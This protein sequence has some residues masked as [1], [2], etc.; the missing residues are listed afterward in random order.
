MTAKRP[1]LRVLH[2]D[3]DES[4]RMLAKRALA[5]DVK[6][7]ERC[8][9]QFVSDGTHALDYVLGR[10]GYSDRREH[11]MPHLLLLDQRMTKMDGIEVIRTL[12]SEEHCCTIPMFLFSTSAQPSLLKACQE[13]GGSFCIRKPLDYSQLKPTL[14]SI[15]NFA[16][17]VLELNQEQ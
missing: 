1:R 3:D 2:A 15:V 16:C 9:F 12:K 4:F 8:H 14:F 6:F 10:N 7:G 17:D 13:A 5:D 11:P